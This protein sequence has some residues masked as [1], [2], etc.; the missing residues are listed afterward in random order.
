MQTILKYFKE[1]S[2]E[3]IHKL[4]QL[5][6]IYQDWNAQINVISRKDFDNFY[7]NHVLHSL[8]ILKY[9]SFA[10]GCR[11]LDVGTGGGFP[12]IPLAI[13]LPQCHFVLND[14]I[15]KK[16]KVVQDIASQLDLKNVNCS[17]V[18]AETI[19]EKFDYITGRAVTALPDFVKLT[20]NKLAKSGKNQTPNGIL[21]LKGGEFSDELKET[22]MKF[23]IFHLHEK[24]DENFFETK[25]L[26]FLFPE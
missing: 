1:L 7:V 11:F 26:V 21:Y 10:P 8:S 19:R 22:G 23:K 25:K 20:E 9:F 6:E 2:S 16:I 17:S 24:F 15:G 18:R 13:C 14:S 12:G 4:S 5:H 3:Q